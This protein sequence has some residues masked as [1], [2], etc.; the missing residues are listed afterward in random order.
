MNK[1]LF[2]QP[3]KKIATARNNAGGKAYEKSNEQILATYAFTSVLGN[4]Y[5]TTGEDQLNTLKSVLPNTD[6]SFIAKLAVCAKK[7]GLMRD[8]PAILVAYL[9]CNNW[10]V[11]N[12]AAAHS[13]FNQVIDNVAML[14]KFVTIM[15]SGVFGRKSLGSFAKKL[16]QRKLNSMSYEQLFRQDIGSNPSLADIIKLSHPDP[17]SSATQEEGKIREA[18][19][20]Y[21]TGNK[22]KNENDLP[23]C[24]KEYE[25]FK[26]ALANNRRAALPKLPF[27]KLAALN[28]SN[29]NWNELINQLG[30]KALIKNLNTAKRHGCL[31]N[32]ATL[33][34]ICD[35]LTSADIVQK[36]SIFP[37]Q[38]FSAYKFAED[39]PKTIVDSLLRATELATS[40][41]PELVGTVAIG[42]DVSGSMSSPITYVNTIASRMRCI[43]VAS[44]FAICLAVKNKGRAR[45]IPFDTSVHISNELSNLSI[46]K[47]ADKLSSYGGGGTNCSLVIDNLLRTN[48]KVDTII[49]ISDN[50]SWAGISRGYK[51]GL[52]SLYEEYKKRFPG[53]KM[54]LLDLTPNRTTQAAP[55]KD[56]LLIAGFSDKIFSL[57]PEFIKNS[58][59]DFWVE[60]IRN[61]TYF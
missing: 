1:E 19:Y 41:I 59:S 14:R 33:Q 46:L 45:I 38:L 13:I 48:T 5:Y 4:T 29:D 39:M 21:L 49:I 42:V 25:G 20:A 53:V 34:K 27:E 17:F 58:S 2:C 36:A 37:Y 57:I 3:N 60:K 30:L 18:F 54:V 31:D 55:D 8:M 56:I 51:T 16:I 40:N 22:I 47:A 15:R 50:E 28:L 26:E 44:L 35:N 32:K 43:D 61:Q 9:I 11:S 12:R 7:E 6:P 10:H 24:V 23:D 52:V